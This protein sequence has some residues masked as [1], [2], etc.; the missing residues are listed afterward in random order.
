MICCLVNRTPA[1]W[2]LGGGWTYMSLTKQW[3]NSLQKINNHGI[4]SFIQRGGKLIEDKTLEEM[5]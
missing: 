2:I 5:C 3:G 4:M 1:I